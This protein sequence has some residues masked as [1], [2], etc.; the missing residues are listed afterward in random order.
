MAL[1]LPVLVLFYFYITYAYSAWFSQDDFGFIAHYDNSIQSNQL[2]DFSN[3]GRFLSRNAYWH[4]GIKY[5]SYNAQFLYFK[6]FYHFVHKLSV[7]QNF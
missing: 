5:F 1:A 2:F 6:S 7:V 3:F 4:F